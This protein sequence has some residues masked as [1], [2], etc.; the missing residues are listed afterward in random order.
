M[1]RADRTEDDDCG[2]CIGDILAELPIVRLALTRRFDDPN[3]PTARD[4]ADAEWGLIRLKRN[5]QGELELELD[6]E[7]VR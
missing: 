7:S 2:R 3:W 4:I 1:S 5:A 6:S